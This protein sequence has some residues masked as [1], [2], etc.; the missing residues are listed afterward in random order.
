MFTLNY[1]TLNIFNTYDIHH[2]II[3]LESD[4]WLKNRK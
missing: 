2:K 4:N 1:Q 3:Q